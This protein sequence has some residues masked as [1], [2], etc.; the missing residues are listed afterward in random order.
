MSMNAVIDVGTNSVKLLVMDASDMS[1]S[2]AVDRVDIVRLGDGASVRRLLSEDAMARAVAAIREMAKTARSLGAE[3]IA[4]V[5]TQALRSAKNAPEFISRVKSACGIDIIIISGEQEARLS[6]EG[7]VSSGMGGASRVCVLDVGGGSSEAVTG[8]QR[9]YRSSVSVPLGALSLHGEH[10]SRGGASDLIG[11]AVLARA[12]A[13]VRNMLAES[14]MNCIRTPGVYCVGVG[15]TI[16][17]LASVMLE[18]DRHEPSRLAGA[19]L[20]RFEIDRQIALYAATPMSER[21]S[22]K[23][24][25]P[26]RADIILSGACIVAELLAFWGADSLA[27]SVRGLRY[28]VMKKLFG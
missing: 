16:T 5:G 1:S 20:S 9:G 24:L 28:G 4:A 13:H 12:R 21:A 6:F 2:P 10:F 23:G 22:I 3:E 7:A 19:E 15:G 27:V 25:S 17:T 8:D 11:D 26:K 14:E 18:L